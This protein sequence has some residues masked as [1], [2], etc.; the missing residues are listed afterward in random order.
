MHKHTKLSARLEEIIQLV[1]T[2]ERVVDVGTD[3]AL[4]PIALV[5]RD[6]AQRGIGI[7]KSSLPLGQAK[8]NRHNAGVSDRLQLI[9]ASGLDVEDLQDT[10]VVIMAGM[11]GRT[12]LEVLQK[13]VWKG[14]LVVQPNRD[15][16]EVRRWLSGHGWYSD[17]ETIVRDGKQF[18]WT[19]RWHRGRR[20]QEVDPLTVEFGNGAQQQSRAVFTEWFQQEYNRLN[21]LPGQ[22][23]DRLK[24]P[25]YHKMAERLSQ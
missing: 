12:M 2:C 13:S 8:V 3:H 23:P 25:L 21:N 1:P 6:V 20:G 7:D 14:C 18:F 22:A 11:G 19:S 24:L 5:S 10:D 16:P 9:C 15:L 4:V 17:V